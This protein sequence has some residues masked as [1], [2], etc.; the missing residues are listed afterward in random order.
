MKDIRE[1]E[2]GRKGEG[3]KIKED[4]RLKYCL[5]RARNSGS[6]WS[7]WRSGFNFKL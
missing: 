3:E 7:G 1:R 5:S 4:H 2:S 6:F